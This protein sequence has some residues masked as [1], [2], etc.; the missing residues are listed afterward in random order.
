LKN[1]I[2]VNGRLLQ[3]N[4]RFSHLKS[5]QKD[6][7]ALELRRMYHNEMNKEGSTKK[8]LSERRSSII[9]TLYEQIQKREIWIPFREV[10]K[11][12]NSKIGKIIKSLNEDITKSGDATEN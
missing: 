8:L 12:A 5:T 7:I 3:K 11:Y 4:K 2:K 6:W 1:H 10:E 9:A